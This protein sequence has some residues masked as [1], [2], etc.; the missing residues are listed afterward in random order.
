MGVRR[1]PYK[2]RKAYGATTASGRG[3][4]WRRIRLVVL[5]RDGNICHY[6]GA[7]A[8]TVDHVRAKNRG[9]T[10]G[11][12]NLVAACTRCNCSKQDRLWP[13]RPSQSPV[14]ANVTS[15]DW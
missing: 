12:G 5:R 14:R 3:A 15:R 4:E 1:G 6:C 13:R 8:N 7:F 2:G 11:L 10:D 9:G